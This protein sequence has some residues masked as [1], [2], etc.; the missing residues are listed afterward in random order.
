MRRPE[1]CMEVLGMM[2][3]GFPDVEGT[4][5]E[6]VAEGDTVAARF[7]VRGTHDGAFF[8]IPASGDKLSVQ[9]MNFS[10]LADGRIVGERDQPGLRSCGARGATAPETGP[11]LTLAPL[12]PTYREV[13]RQEPPEPSCQGG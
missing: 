2:R 1:G 7:T 8:G 12:H 9:A 6:T 13:T 5:E 4:L 10:Y 11:P 3:G